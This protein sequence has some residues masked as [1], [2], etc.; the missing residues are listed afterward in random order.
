MFKSI[1]YL[2][3]LGVISVLIAG[4]N[5]TACGDMDGPKKPLQTPVQSFKQATIL[6]GKV[7]YDIDLIK[8]VI[9]SGTVKVSNQQQ[10]I[11]ASTEVQA[12]KYQVEIPAATEL[13]II[14]TF[15]PDAE[16]ENQE[17]M[18][19][20]VVYNSLTK[21]NITPMTTAIAQQAK[22]MG[23]YTAANI[24]LAAESTTHTPDRNNTSSSFQGDPSKRYGGWH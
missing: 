14:L 10:K 21:Y 1:I 24:I 3:K 19:A 12:G 6:K 8:N 7:S 16:A 20:V 22:K 2:P 13:P 11:L 5:L 23:G 18:W 17:K 9:K 15:Y 4:I